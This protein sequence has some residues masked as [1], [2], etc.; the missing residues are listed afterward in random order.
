VGVLGPAHHLIPAV[1]GWL[2]FAG[3]E[4]PDGHPVRV[5]LVVAFLLLGPGYAVAGPGRTV[6]AGTVTTVATSCAL[7]ALVAQAHFLTGTF[8]A[9]SV[10]AT[11]AGLTTT[12]AFIRTARH[13]LP[14]RA[15]TTR[16]PNV[17]ARRASRPGHPGHPYHEHERREHP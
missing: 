6:L 11:L 10:L 17:R 13:G 4:L 8:S 7:C 15:P 2:A 14:T 5:V 9:A 16:T 1:A 3:L 12:A